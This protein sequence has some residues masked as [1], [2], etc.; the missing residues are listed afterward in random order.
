MKKISTCSLCNGTKLKFLYETRD[1]NRNF[2]GS[3]GQFRCEECGL[4]FL[5]PQP[6]AKELEKYYSRGEEDTYYSYAPIREDG[7]WI[8]YA[9][10][11]YRMS[12][13]AP[14]LNSVILYPLSSL[15]RGVK[16][17]PKGKHLDVGCGGGQFF[18]E[19]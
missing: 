19:L 2:E 15:A 1:Y 12:V 6:T 9:R 18:Y 5:N 17:V 13:K 3:F 8:K 14:L 16:I 4:I 11:F 10:F 7:F